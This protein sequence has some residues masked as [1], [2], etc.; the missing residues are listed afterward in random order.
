ALPFNSYGTLETG[1]LCR[2]WTSLSEELPAVL[3]VLNLQRCAPSE[4]ETLEHLTRYFF[5][6]P[7]EQLGPEAEAIEQGKGR[8]VY[9]KG[10]GQFPIELDDLVTVDIDCSVAAEK[11][12]R[13]YLND[14]AVV[15]RFVQSTGGDPKRLDELVEQLPENVEHFWL[16]RYRQLDERDRSVVDVLALAGRPL[17]LDRLYCALS[18]FS[19]ADYMARATRELVDAGL[20]ER[21]IGDGEVELR[22]EN[23]SFAGSVVESLEAARK[24]RI[25]A[26]FAE[27]ALRADGDEVCPV[28]VARHLLAAGDIDRGLEYARQAVRR[29][30]NQREYDQASDLLA[31]VLEH[32]DDE[33]Q[34]AR[35]HQQLIAAHR[36][37]GHYRKALTHCD[38]LEQLVES[39]QERARLR[40]ERGHL[41]LKLSEYE[42]ALELFGKSA[43]EAD[44]SPDLIEIWLEAKLGESEANYA[45]GLH[46]AARET[47]VD[48]LERIRQVE[49]TSDGMRRVYDYAVVR[50]RNILVKVALVMGDCEKARTLLETNRKLAEEWGWDDELA[51]VQANMGLVAL[52]EKKFDRAE[53]C[54]CQSL[55]LARSPDVVPRSYTWLNLAIILQMKSE[56]DKAL[57]YCLEGMR[58]ARR[59]SDDAVYSIAAHNL[60]TIYVAVGAYDRALSIIERVRE[61]SDHFE[62]RFIGK[63]AFDI[64]HADIL[65]RTRRYEKSL[66]KLAQIDTSQ[67]HNQTQ[68]L[69]IREMR[70]R[71]IEAHLDVGQVQMARQVLEEFDRDELRETQPQLLAL[72]HLGRAWIDLH[73]G[74]PTTALEFG[75]EAAELAGDGGHYFDRVSAHLTYA[76]ALLAEERGAE[77]RAYLEETLD[78]VCRRVEHVPEAHRDDYFAVP[79]H[80]EVAALAQ[81]TGAEI[82]A[83]LRRLDAEGDEST[84][85]SDADVD[86]PAFR[87]WRSRYKEIIGEDPKLH[88][89]FRVV[90][91]VAE[92]DSPV[93]IQGESGTG[94]ELMAEAV[95]AESPRANGPFVKVNCAAFVE[96]LLL[97]ELFGHVKGAF[98]GA[99]SEREGRFEMADGGTIF[100]D[101]IGDIS[102]KTQVSLLRVLQEGTFEKVGGTETKQ[103]DVRVICATNKSLETMVEEGEFRLDLY[104]RLKGVIM[105]VPPL[106]E[107]R[108][109]I[110]RLVQHFARDCAENGDLK[111][112]SAEVMQFLSSYSWP[113][114]VRELQNFVKNILLFV[115]GT[116]VEMSHLHELGEFFSD[117]RVDES[118]PDIDFEVELEDY[119]EV[120]ET[121]ENP[122]G[123]LVDRIVAE[124][125]SLSGIKKQ[126]ELD[127]I[128]LALKQTGGN[129]TQAAKI[130]QMKRPRLSQIVNSTEELLALKEELVG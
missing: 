125:L 119:Q 2:L 24:E 76:R 53:E 33:E 124:G 5:A 63:Y 39:R 85:A 55:E 59:A 25:H 115:E 107:R 16:H 34:L 103:V 20:L 86:N 62:H 41:L 17:S 27:A 106:R 56:Y 101:E 104:Y 29:L 68:R 48:V 88:Q 35:V 81:K 99:V 123:A 83:A 82:P 78:E 49:D 43:R 22:V 121:F 46:D 50:A 94:K 118:L 129:I 87:R 57:R 66:Q 128:G 113:G 77:A 32:T 91:R 70:L 72:H 4:R 10:D 75:P 52:E 14:P 108:Q 95:H 42:K 12:V 61:E 98:T 97:S 8:L 18:E 93:L 109:D 40:C 127:A 74:D 69:P 30:L 114:N 105:E 44:D 38:S 116:T 45:G 60:V 122:E 31:T 110:P 111:R 102:P 100:L 1:S 19:N 11:T 3:M 80:Q 21:T 58:A 79:L 73:D 67:C 92:S 130:L 90:D 37:L 36:A 96:D 117:G 126:L 84:E 65:H 71:S 28:F 47:V 64:L 23:S 9:L 112:F 89:L 54:I 15:R 6:D 13:Q 51:R 26:A 120:G 7:I